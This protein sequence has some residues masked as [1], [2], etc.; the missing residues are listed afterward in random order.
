MGQR[1]KRDERFSSLFKRCYKLYLKLHPDRESFLDSENNRGRKLNY[2]DENPSN[3]ERNFPVYFGENQDKHRTLEIC[4]KNF[5]DQFQR[6]KRHKRNV[7]EGNE[8]RFWTQKLDIN[9]VRIGQGRQNLFSC[10]GF[11]S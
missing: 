9:D 3:F 5:G 7:G 8:V 4:L 2:L 1:Q 6:R 10:F 11:N